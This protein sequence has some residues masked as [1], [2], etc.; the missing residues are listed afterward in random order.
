MRVRSLLLSLVLAFGC[1]SV[2]AQVPDG[3]Y[4]NIDGKFGED[5]KT[6]L[7]QIIAEHKVFSY[8]DL[9]ETYEVTDVVPGTKDQIQEYYSNKVMYY[10][11]RGTQI[12]R[13]H[14]VPQSWWGGGALS[15][16][17][18]DL[19]NVLPAESSANGQKSNFP[20]GEVTGTPK[21][22][23]GVVKVGPSSNSGGAN[24]VFEPSDEF[25]GDFAR[26]YFYVATCYASAPWKSTAYSMMPT[27]PTLAAWTIPML[28]AWS[29]DDPVDEREMKR[30]EAC[31]F[32]QGNRNPFV[33]YPQLA[34]Y[35]WG[36]RQVSYFILSDETA[37]VPSQ[38]YTFHFKAARPTFSVQYGVTPETAQG[39]VENTV[40]KVSAG[41]SL[42]TIFC[43]V[44]DG[45]WVSSSADESKNYYSPY[46]NFTITNSDEPTK[47]EAYTARNERDNSDTIV[48]YYIVADN[49]EFLL[50]DDFAT[51]SSGDNMSTSGHSAWYGNSNF[52]EGGLEKVYQAGGALKLG[53]GS[54]AGSLTSRELEFDG[55]ALRVELD[56][57]GWT[58]LE[59]KLVVGVTG[60]E[61]QQIEYS[62]TL[63]DAFEHVE[64]VF[65]NCSANPVVK[66]STSSKRLF[67]DNVSVTSLEATDI[68]N[69]K[70]SDTKVSG[71]WYT[72]TGCRL[73]GRPAKAGIYI[74]NGNKVYCSPQ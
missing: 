41:N 6:T 18:T 65:E 46:K 37:N 61:E 10:T 22:D 44:N 67:I 20:L 33:D 26:I 4:Q 40:V 70:D 9:W 66:I 51:A 45:E 17:Y 57:K 11:S 68:D 12:N 1:V 14:T 39:V 59:S 53:T 16:A 19:F 72:L 15:N 48:A 54:A 28:L 25:K 56:V 31:Y 64:A 50:Y 5:L 52:P 71:A 47:I 58:K 63:E 27:E 35:I 29:N 21:F 32:L 74:V 38:T 30:N 7:S 13:E 8:G 60:C 43:R 73:S 23:N 3:Y 34:D 42:G 2:M 55:G 62:A 49:S 24:Y 36:S 69:V